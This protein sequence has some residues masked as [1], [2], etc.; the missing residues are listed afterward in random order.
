MKGRKL[1]EEHRR[2]ISEAHKGMRLSEESKRKIG[3][4]QKGNKYCL[5]RK[6]S[7]ETK[8]KI[9]S[10]KRAR[11]HI[12]IPGPNKGKS[13]SEETKLKISQTLKGRIF[14]DEH[15]R[16]LCE[17]NKGRPCSETTR[18]K[19]KAANLGKGSGKNV[20]EITKIKLSIA[21]KKY[22]REHPDCLLGENNPAWRGGLS[23][24]PYCPKFNNEFKERVRAFFGYRC[25][26][27]GH[28]WQLGERKLAVHHVNFDKQTCCNDSIPLFVPI[29]TGKC[30][31]KTNHNRPFWEDWFTEIINEFYGGKCYFSKEEM[32]DY[33]N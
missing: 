6:L 21:S 11:P 32:R 28:L 24:E 31:T 7:E 5:G 4:H 1:S 25:Q 16:K 10:T 30:H 27:C 26:I 12:M 17:A 8:L 14:T 33:V 2:K 3:A 9:S 23:F 13:M 18:K 29:C 22:I 15:R 20:S 19:I